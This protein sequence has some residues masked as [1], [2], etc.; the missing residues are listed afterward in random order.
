MLNKPEGADGLNGT[1][2]SHNVTS[3]TDAPIDRGENF[4]SSAFE[5]WE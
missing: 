5:F 4:S 1:D 2:V 3:F